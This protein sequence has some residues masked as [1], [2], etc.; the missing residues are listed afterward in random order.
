MTLRIVLKI[1]STSP[2]QGTRQQLS[3][4]PRAAPQ[5]AGKKQP[6]LHTCWAPSAGFT[7]ASHPAW[8]MI[9]K[10]SASKIQGR[11]NILTTSKSKK[12]TDQKCLLKIKRNKNLQNFLNFNTAISAVSPY[13]FYQTKTPCSH[14]KAFSISCTENHFSPLQ[15]YFYQY[16]G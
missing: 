13:S 16:Q 12:Q 6:R 5:R 10:W 14:K 9:I 7:A 3:G 2:V 1:Y 8:E 11:K 15:H 4:S